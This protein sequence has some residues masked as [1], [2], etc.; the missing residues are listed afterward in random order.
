MSTAYYKGHYIRFLKGRG[1]DVLG[2]LYPSLWDATNF[3]DNLT[4]TSH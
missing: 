1:Y 2:T 3:I 4:T